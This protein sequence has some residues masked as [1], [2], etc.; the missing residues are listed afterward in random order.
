MTFVRFSRLRLSVRLVNFASFNL[1]ALLIA[2]KGDQRSWISAFEKDLQWMG[3]VA[4]CAKFSTREW[5]DLCRTEPKRARRIIRTAC[6]SEEA[7][8]LSLAQFPKA[9]V[10]FA[11]G[12]SCQCGKVC[13]T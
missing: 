8:I 12:F 13:K 5:F 11:E 7:R 10:R 2:A 6:D 3:E 4:A 9:L 1:I